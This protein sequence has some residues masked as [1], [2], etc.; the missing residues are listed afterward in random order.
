MIRKL[1]G[2]SG[3][4]LSEYQRASGELGVFTL[5]LESVEDLFDPDPLWDRKYGGS[6][7]IREKAS[8]AED[9]RLEA[10]LDGCR[11]SVFVRDE[12]GRFREQ[13]P[14]FTDIVMW[15]PAAIWDA[16][17]LRGGRKIEAL[18]SNLSILHRSKFRGST[19]DGREPIYTV[20]PDAA[21][22]DQD[23]AFQ[24]GFG[25]FVP[26]EEDV[27]QAELTMRRGGSGEAHAFA[28]WSFWQDGAQIQRPAGVYRGQRS[29]LIA[30]NAEAPIRAPIWFPHQEG[31]ILIN[32][33]A[34]DTQRIYTDEEAIEVIDT[35]KP[36]KRGDPYEWF[37]ADRKRAKGG[38][39]KPSD[40]IVIQVTPLAKAVRIAERGS[41]GQSLK[42]DTVKA[43]DTPADPQDDVTRILDAQTAAPEQPQKPAKETGTGKRWF[44]MDR[45]LGGLSRG[46]GSD[47]TPLSDR[48]TL[49]LAGLA[50][51]RIDGEH[52]LKGL[53]HWTVFLDDDGTPVRNQE[54]DA[55]DAGTCLALQASGRDDKLYYRLAD[56]RSF[57]PVAEIP[58]V[59]PTRHKQYLDLL[60]SPV[61]DRYLGL[62]LF[63]QET[64]FPLSPKPL[65]LGRSNMDPKAAQP[66]LPLEL[67]THPESLNWEPGGGYSGAKLN[68]INL[69]RRHVSVRLRDGELD[70][71]M[72]E[73]TSPV[74]ILDED[75][76]RLETLEPKS[77]HTLGLK[78]GQTMIVGSYLLRFHEERART[79]VSSEHSA[80][81]RRAGA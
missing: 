59:L 66:D 33:N 8:G 37:L 70:L 51:M 17:A 49:R 29:V 36:A 67:L 78:P 22:G 34:A 31:H 57:K 13:N 39:P 81:R 12:A 68:A 10:A 47:A 16:E 23:I 19:P 79:M 65:L 9:F 43:P 38:K 41:T 3:D 60:P 74:Y 40:R 71:E 62:L 20:M 35:R 24:F 77:K 30:P 72:D 64:A 27:L 58:C 69:S 76:S 44:G 18:A 80:L 5:A 75:G 14:V 32:L 46:R 50:L 21:L 55:I 45:L 42:I 11:N 56:E 6:S 26:H 15:I 2:R 1:F 48:Y 54:A 53:A 7:R 4:V 63:K 73:G 52:R 61:P 25:V 28:E